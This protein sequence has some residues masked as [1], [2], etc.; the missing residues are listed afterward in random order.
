MGA[1]SWRQSGAMLL[2]LPIACTPR[3]LDTHSRTLALQRIDTSPVAV[4]DSV[5]VR[6]DATLVDTGSAA[7]Y[8]DV[9]AIMTNH[10]A[11]SVRVQFSRCAIGVSLRSG[12]GQY[13]PLTTDACAL[14]LLEAIIPSLGSRETHRPFP[15]PPVDSVH[16]QG[17]TL[18]A[19]LSLISPTGQSPPVAIGVLHIKP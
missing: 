8:G 11:R 7:P 5:T 19:E 12:G 18:F 3:L 2:A 4:T 14:V 15:L 9:R 17:D 10:A 13:D 6:F 1:V 16:T